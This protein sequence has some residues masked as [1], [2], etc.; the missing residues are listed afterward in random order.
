MFVL[1]PLSPSVDLSRTVWPSL[2]ACTDPLLPEF[3][4]CLDFASLSLTCSGVFR[5]SPSGPQEAVLFWF[6][7]LF[8]GAPPPGPYTCTQGG[9]DLQTCFLSSRTGC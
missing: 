4:T 1:M 6:R 2:F 5:T 9:H 7:F 8:R 3:N